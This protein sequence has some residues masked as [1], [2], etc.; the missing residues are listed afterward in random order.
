MAIKMLFFER[1]GD[2]FA[3]AN[4]P[5]LRSAEEWAA[6]K[7]IAGKTKKELRGMF[8]QF[9]KDAIPTSLTQLDK[10]LRELAT[11]TFKCIQGFMGDAGFC[12]PL[13]LAQVGVARRGGRSVVGA[14]WWAGRGGRGVVG[15]A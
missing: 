11:Q 4:F 13:M 12:Y 9:Q 6:A 7:R 2:M 1:T 15:G 3:L 8:L 10:S 14:A 5:Q